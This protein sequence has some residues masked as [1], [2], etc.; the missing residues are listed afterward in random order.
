ML[1]AG[2]NSDSHLV[3]LS[4]LQESKVSTSI[5]RQRKLGFRPRDKML[6]GVAI[7]SVPVVGGQFLNLK[8]LQLLVRWSSSPGTS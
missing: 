1:T 7:G 2:Y 8:L 6:K 4:S 5:P 3:L